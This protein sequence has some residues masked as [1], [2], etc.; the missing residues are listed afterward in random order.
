MTH[1]DHRDANHQQALIEDM[2]VN[3]TQA[4]DVKGGPLEIRELHIKVQVSNQQPS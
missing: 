1:Q 4:M 2:T 3:P